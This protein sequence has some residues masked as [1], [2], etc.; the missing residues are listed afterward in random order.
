MGQDEERQ[1]RQKIQ[2]VLDDIVENL[3][4]IQQCYAFWYSFTQLTD[5]PE[6]A[7]SMHEVVV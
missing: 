3:T 2:T 4:V 5:L 1:I 7:S 6:V